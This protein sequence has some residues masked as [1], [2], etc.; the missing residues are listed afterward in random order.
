[1][2]QN[3][4]KKRRRWDFAA[5]GESGD[6]SGATKVLFFHGHPAAPAANKLHGLKFIFADVLR[7][8][9]RF[10]AKTTLCL[11]VARIAQMPGRFRDGAAILTR[12]GHRTRSFRIDVVAPDHMLGRTRPIS[13]PATRKSR[14]GDA[15]H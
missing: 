5:V 2:G 9:I 3:I 12:I 11:I 15:Q 14:T 8:R 6:G 7:F 1:M 10:S 4:W 13:L